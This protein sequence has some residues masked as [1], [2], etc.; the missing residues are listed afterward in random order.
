MKE[1]A[2]LRNAVAHWYVFSFWTTIE[3][4]GTDE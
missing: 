4:Y 2:T 1:N 3:V